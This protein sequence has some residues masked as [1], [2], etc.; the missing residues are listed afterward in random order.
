MYKRCP[1]CYS[2]DPRI[3]PSRGPEHCLRNHAQYVCAA[4]GRCIC[5]DVGKGGKARW[6]FPFKN[7]DIAR[8]YIRAA[9]VIVGGSCAIYEFE[10]SNGRRFAKIF[11]SDD[12]RDTY[13]QRNPD[14]RLKS[15]EPVFV[16][17]SYRPLQEGQRRRLTDQKVSQ[18]M[19]EK[20]P[21]EK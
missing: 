20:Y 7:V 4:C 15:K 21:K 13:C 11:A 19:E 8:L 12:D 1:E 9:E 2:D 5:A 3:T 17:S 18:Y 16:T 14:K 6:R 10:S